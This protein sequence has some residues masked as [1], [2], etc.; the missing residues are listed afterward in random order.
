VVGL[1]WVDV[2][3]ATRRSPY[4]LSANDASV[5][6]KLPHPPTTQCDDVRVAA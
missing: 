3:V 4:R 5:R 6:N 1:G 2:A